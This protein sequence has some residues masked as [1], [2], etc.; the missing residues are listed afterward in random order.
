M[1]PDD[2]LVASIEASNGPSLDGAI[3]P[4]IVASLIAPYIDGVLFVQALRRRGMSRGNDP[5]GWGEVDLA[6]KAPPE[7]TEQLL[8][9]EKY[10]AREPA[11][12]VAR[13]TPPGET[14]W[15]TVYE[16]VFGEQGLR[17]TAEQW[18]PRKLAAAVAQ[19]WGGDRLALFRRVVRG[20][21]SGEPSATS[22]G[23][24]SSTDYAVAWHIR[25]D[26]GHP[27]V[28]GEARQ[29]FKALADGLHLRPVGNPNTVCV[30]RGSLGPFA[31]TRAGRDLALTAG[32]YEHNRAEVRS[33]SV[34]PQTARWA[35]D[36][37]RKSKP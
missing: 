15:S 24:V 19:G 28:D 32:P 26:A 31:V 2:Q 1:I 22:D 34:C 3:P 5:T 14:G 17:I 30:E 10:D 18:M 12:T 21:S 36:I 25:F 13:I 27:D 9:V 29:A 11:E 37:L 4:V 6:W 8:H 33:A 16:D 7:T 35:A 23:V 20:S